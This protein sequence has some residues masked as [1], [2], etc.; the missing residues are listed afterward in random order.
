M[1]I[2]KKKPWHIPESQATPEDMYLNRRQFVKKAG[3]YTL[4]AGV[5]FTG[6]GSLIDIF[7]KRK[8]E[9][10]KVPETPTSNLYPAK[11]NEKYTLNRPLT[12]EK[13]AGKYNNF[14]EFSSGKSVWRNV[15]KM[16]VRPWTVEVTG[17]VEKPQVYDIDRLVKEMPLE[18]RLY[19]LRCV[20]AWAMAVPWT[21]FS[22][23]EFIKKV[24]PLSSAKYIRFQTFLNKD[25]APQQ[26]YKFW[27][28]WPYNEGLSMA[29]ATNELAFLATGIYGHELP[30][31]HGAPI[32]LVVPWKYGFK[33]IKSI[34]KIEFTDKQPATFWN[35]VVPNEYDFLANVNPDV[36]HPRW[37]QAT[38]RIIDTDER[39]PTI[40]YNGYGKYVAGIYEKA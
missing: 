12:D 38:E 30:K 4:S 24:K 6:T 15:D 32:R 7:G 33:S 3:L 29:E 20:E 16:E 37:S 31:Q 39:V 1:F 23:A 13:V 10:I 40:K 22:M 34:V 36:P 25:W 35:T 28:P 21:G 8:E 17:L 11:K 19:R 2:K 26:K 27:H 5:L 9:M 18:E 14:Y